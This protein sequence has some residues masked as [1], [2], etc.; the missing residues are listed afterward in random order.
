[1]MQLLGDP[2]LSVY[3]DEPVDL[4][5]SFLNSVTIGNS[6][7]EVEVYGIPDGETAKV[8]I[9]KENEVYAIA[10]KSSGSIGNIVF[11]IAPDTP[12]EIKLIVTCHN[13]EPYESEIEN[14]IFVDQIPG[15]HLY[16]SNI[17]VGNL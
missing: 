13:A 12:G 5:V 16:Q 9:Y 3:T 6:D 14:P 15:V 17:T 4:T 2:E 10:Q 1:M 7:F 8:C 11:S